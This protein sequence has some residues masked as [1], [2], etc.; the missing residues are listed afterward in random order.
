MHWLPW[1]DLYLA[2]RSSCLGFKDISQTGPLE[3]LVQQNFESVN[4]DSLIF[5]TVLARARLFIFIYYLVEQ[6][7]ERLSTLLPYHLEQCDKCSL[8]NLLL[9]FSHIHKV[10]FMNVK[11]LV[12]M[13]ACTPCMYEIP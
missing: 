6:V 7:L 5:V 12:Y 13:Y 8:K 11:C 1:A 3:I 4:F 9:I 2:A 10:Y